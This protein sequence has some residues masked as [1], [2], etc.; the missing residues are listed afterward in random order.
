VLESPDV[1]TSRS[2]RDVL[3]ALL[4]F[5][6]I[7][8]ALSPDDE[9]LLSVLQDPAAILPNGDRLL[10]TVTRWE[11]GSLDVLLKRFGVT[12]LDLA[13]LDTFRRVYDAYAQVAALGIPASALLAATTNEPTVDALH[14]VDTVRDLQSALRARYDQEAD[15]LQVLKPINDTLRALQRDALVACVLQHLGEDSKT[16]AIDTPDKLLEYFLM[17]VQMEPCMQTSRIRHALSSVQLFVERCLMNLEPDLA[18]ASIDPAKWA[19]MKRYRVWEANRKVF[20]W[21]ENWLEPELRDDQ[22]PI[23]RET[24]SELL[25]SDITEDTAATALLNYLSRLEEVAK[26][27]PCG[28]HYVENSPGKQG[29]IVHV[30]A[31]TAGAQH[32]YYYR[33]SDHPSWTP[34][35]QIKLDIEDNPVIPVVW[36]DRLLLFWLRILK[37]SPGAPPSSKADTKTLHDITPDDVKQGT[38]VTMTVQAVLCWSEYYNGKWQPTKTS[39]VDRPTTLGQQ[40]EPGPPDPNHPMRFDRSQ[41]R[42]RVSEEGDALRVRVRIFADDRLSSFL[43][44][45]THSLPAPEEDVPDPDPDTFITPTSRWRFLTRA[46]EMLRIIYPPGPSFSNQLKC[47]VLTDLIPFTTVQPQHPL[48]DTWDAPFFFQDSRHLFY[49]STSESI[50][51]VGEFSG[52]GMSASPAQQGIDIP[53][54]VLKQDP[55]VIPLQDEQGLRISGSDHGFVDPSPLARFVSEDRNIRT[56]IGTTGSVSFGNREIGPAGELADG[57]LSQP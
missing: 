40:F 17:D 56:A 20:L 39:D 14:N 11:S 49:V 15:W 38:Q 27:E 1:P 41:L 57:H 3:A 31:R 25:Q 5:A 53:P 36:K 34:W 43:L 32:K 37:Q 23:F 22:S 35:E 45:N 12:Q 13:H 30:V 10:L 50:T 24:M 18:P 51:T 44:Y 19:W 2:L 54:L 46:K 21:P 26:L 47:D 28:I 16:S 33:R 42:L 8:A 29:S 9:R 4:D 52:H 7:K 48:Q 55:N 6:R